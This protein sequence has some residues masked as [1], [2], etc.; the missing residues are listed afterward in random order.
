MLEIKQQGGDIMT[1]EQIIKKCNEKTDG[2]KIPFIYEN[3]PAILNN[4]L[5]GK[6][7]H[8]ILKMV[9]DSDYYE[10]DAR[11]YI[12]D[13]QLISF[14]TAFESESPITEVYFIREVL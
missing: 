10:E 6:T 12:K 5:S 3:T 8:E 14:T 7:P 2:I 1:D 9:Q 13:G 11:F 4:I